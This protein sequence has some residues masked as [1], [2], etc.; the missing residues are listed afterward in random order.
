MKNGFSVVAP[1]QDHH[2]L[3]DVGQ[4]HV[5]LGLVEAVDFVDEQQRPLPVGREPVVGRG[6]DLA[7]FLHA[8]GHGAD[9]LEVA[10]AF[11]G[12]A[13]G[14]AWSCR[15]PAGRKRSP[16]PGGRPPAAGAAACLRR[17]SAAGRRT[18]PACRAASAPPAAGPSRRF[19]SRWLQKA[20]WMLAL[21]GRCGRQLPT[22]WP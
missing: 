14:P 7:Q 11:A 16:S 2:A 20:T 3:L 19:G 1:D 18:R 10:A 15:C 9:L 13:A 4:Q 12:P 5:L 8:A 22:D 17:G 6:E 21:D